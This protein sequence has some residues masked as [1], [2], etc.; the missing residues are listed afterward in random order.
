MRLSALFEEFTHYL[1][2]EREAAPRTIQTYRSC[3]KDFVD[4]VRK[5]VGGTVL[6]SHF[7]PELCRGYQYDLAARGL[8]TNSIRVRLATLG[9][10]G[11]WAVRRERLP[12]NPLELLTRP[13]RRARLPRT[14]RWTT[15]EH[16]L[17][18]SARLRDR[19]ILALLSY[20]GLRRSEVVALDVE[21][22]DPEFGL[23]RVRGK[24]GH[25]A[26]V[27]LPDV[28]RAILSEYLEK[29]RPQAAP[30]E[31]LFLVRYRTKGRT[32]REQRISDHRVWKLVRDLG[33]RVGLPGLHPHA[34]RHACG[35]ELLRR[36]AGNL[37]AVQ[38]HLRH[39]DI[40][41][42]TIY[43]R[44]TQ[45]ELQRVVRVFDAKGN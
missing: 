38:E 12:R 21:D 44:L 11:K 5:E 17:D 8:H 33:R 19:A 29:E 24:G 31:P 42:T 34:L 41:T 14:P 37:R 39:A 1:R 27:P 20:G 16:L 13:R 28:A 22:Y 43:T 3:F 45:D 32:W 40:Q 10:L 2:V 9:S 18:R 30:A 6:V 7:T 15:V 25:E 23:R 4:F 26:A 36:T 35:V